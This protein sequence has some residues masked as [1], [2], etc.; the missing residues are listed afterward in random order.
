MDRE[1]KLYHTLKNLLEAAERCGLNGTD[2]RD[3]FAYKNAKEILNQSE[4]EY[5]HLAKTLNV[6][7]GDRLHQAREALRKRL[8]I[9]DEGS[10]NL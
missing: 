2:V 10:S 5:A 8:G 7:G 1:L 4:I 9:D 6:I 3:S